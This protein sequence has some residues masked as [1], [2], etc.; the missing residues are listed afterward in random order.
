VEELNDNVADPDP[1]VFTKDIHQDNKGEQYVNALDK[2]MSDLM[3]SDMLTVE[4]GPGDEQV[5]YLRVDTAPSKIKIAF[6]ITSEDSSP[7]DF[8]VSER[9]N[10]RVIPL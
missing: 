10:L 2:F 4:L 8:K 6:S 3:P 1:S 9:G 5:F 7:V